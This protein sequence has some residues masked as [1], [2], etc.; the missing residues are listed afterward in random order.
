MNNL[1]PLQ[2]LAETKGCL[3]YTIN[4]ATSL[5]CVGSKKK[6]DIF[7]WQGTQL[8]FAHRKEFIRAESP[9]GLFCLRT[10]T[11]VIVGNKRTYDHV[12]LVSGS[13]PVKVTCEQYTIYSGQA[14]F[15]HTIC[16]YFNVNKLKSNLRR[17]WM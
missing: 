2:Q 10:G 17:F 6:I 4:E 11:G 1:A 5:L 16:K 15:F 14:H 9:R 8:G 7:V 13:N 12:D 3:L